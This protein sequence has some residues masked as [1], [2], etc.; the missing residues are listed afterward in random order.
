MIYLQSISDE[1]IQLFADQC[2][3]RKSKFIA[4]YLMENEQMKSTIPASRKYMKR[5]AAAR[6]WQL[7]IPYGNQ[8]SSLL[9]AW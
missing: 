6:P 4:M 3:G 2:Q 1:I 5:D 7:V 9:K 8:M